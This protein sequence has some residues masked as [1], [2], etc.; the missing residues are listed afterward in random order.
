MRVLVAGCGAMGLPMAEAL[1][2]ARVDTVGFDINLTDAIEASALPMVSSVH[3][4]QA[5]TLLLVVRSA[6]DIMDVCFDQQAIFSAANVSPPTSVIVSSTVSSG[7]V[8]ALRQRLDPSIELLEAPMSG[9]PIAARERRLS[10]MLAGNSNALDKHQFLFEAMGSTFFR[11]GG[12]GQGMLVKT[13]NNTLAACSVLVTRRV[14]ADAE[15]EGVDTD[16]LLNVLNA[17]SGATW[18]SQNFEKID[19]ANEGYSAQSTI[20][21]LEKDMR[22]ALASLSRDADDFDKALI[23]SLTLLKPRD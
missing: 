6:Q 23:R 2:A 1:L 21:I 5:D 10:F 14:L 17:S 19:W 12:L 11:V 22:S 15:A 8:I 16:L 18:F 13:L 9:A 4:A 3:D 20:G 7:D